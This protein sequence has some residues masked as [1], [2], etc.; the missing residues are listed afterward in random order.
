ML[1]LVP[2]LIDLGL[3]LPDFVMSEI[4]EPPFEHSFMLTRLA[5][6][7]IPGPGF[8]DF[9]TR[10]RHIEDIT[11]KEIVAS[12]SE[13]RDIDIKVLS[14][15][16]HDALPI[17]KRADAFFMFFPFLARYR[18]LSAVY[19][20]EIRWPDLLVPV[21]EAI[22]RTSVPLTYLG[23]DLE[24]KEQSFEHGIGIALGALNHFSKSLED[25]SLRLLLNTPRG[26]E[27]ITA[28][29]ISGRE[30]LEVGPHSLCSLPS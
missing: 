7:V 19:L 2:N 9:L 12:D 29:T 22:S 11:C 30:L 10:Q 27:S 26:T 3:L 24:V 18:P 15:I 20:R 21:V 4:L 14:N 6:R 17:L 16:H 8:S 13:V 28:K 23:A 5:I 25:I 1:S